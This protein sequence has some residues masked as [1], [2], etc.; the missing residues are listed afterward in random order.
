MNPVV[1]YILGAVVALAGTIAALIM[2]TPA[3]KRDSLNPFFKFLHD[4]FNF[5]YLIIEKILQFCYI[6]ATLFCIGCGFF[7]L[8]SG[9]SFFGHFY[10]MAGTGILL[11]LLGPVVI[12]I[13]YEFV[14]M[15]ILA[16]KNIIQINN[17]LK[18]Q[19]EGNVESVFDAQ[20]ELN[21]KND[22]DAQ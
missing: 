16:V 4:L 1:A 21:F 19:N 11:L 22:N 18:N 13:A 5:K 9:Y 10:S 2:I 7:L 6:L 8:F 14:M 12:R 15:A 17:K 20:P 3:R